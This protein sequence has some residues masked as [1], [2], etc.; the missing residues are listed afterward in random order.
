[1]RQPSPHSR[2]N[3]ARNGRDSTA[4]AASETDPL[5]QASASSF[6][7][8]R[9]HTE[10]HGGY[11]RA[12]R[13]SRSPTVPLNQHFGS[14]NNQQQEQMNTTR[15]AD[16]PENDIQHGYNIIQ[17]DSRSGN[18]SMGDSSRFSTGSIQNSTG[19]R[20]NT[21][22]RRQYLA[23]KRERETTSGD[24]PPL[25]EIP[26]EIYGVRTA[27]LQVLKPLTKTWVSRYIG[28][29]KADPEFL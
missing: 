14:L 16:Q 13:S 19:S 22:I 15:E 21:S 24:H 12:R 2:D 11:I 27:A 23:D 18:V 28:Y 1:M 25:L 4:T 7:R 29:F 20:S 10:S 5:L 26:E 17:D 9:N 8:R 6:T 3:T